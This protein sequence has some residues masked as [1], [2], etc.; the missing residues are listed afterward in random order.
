MAQDDLT[1]TQGARCY[2]CGMDTHEH[3]R[4]RLR[5]LVAEYGSQVKLAAACGMTEATV[6]RLIR[7]ENNASFESLLQLSDG[8]NRPVEWFLRDVALEASTHK[9]AAE[10]AQMCAVVRRDAPDTWQEI[11]TLWQAEMIRRRRGGGGTRT[12]QTVRP[13]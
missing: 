4:M 1:D 5:E 6:S 12:D 3:I 7:G 10:A 2:A 13:A 9:S 8:T 11:Q